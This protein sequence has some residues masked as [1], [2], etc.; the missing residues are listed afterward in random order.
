MDLYLVLNISGSSVLAVPV[1]LLY[2]AYRSGRREALAAHE[3][4]RL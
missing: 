4:I 1:D 2:L 3:E